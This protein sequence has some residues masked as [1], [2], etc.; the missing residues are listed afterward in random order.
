MNLYD[1]EASIL[2]CVDLESGEIVDFERMEQLEMERDKKITQL[3]LW[4]KNLLADAEAYKKEKDAFEKKR[5][6]AANKAESIKN[7]LNHYLNGCA[8]DGDENKRV[9]IS[10]R[11]SKSIQ[12]DMEKLLKMEGFETY[13]KRQDP[14]A[15][16]TVIKAAL[17]MGLQVDGCTE[18]ENL[19]IQIK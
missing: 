3:A 16:K 18:V 10:F 7:Y 19:N 5:K 9:K 12:V 11:K 2:E 15:D 13:I 6:V 1:I 14:E 17:D 4:Y 8:W